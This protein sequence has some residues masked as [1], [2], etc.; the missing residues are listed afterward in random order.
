MKSLGAR[1]VV[2]LAVACVFLQPL[3]VVRAAESATAQ[4]EA[5]NRL[6]EQGRFAEAASAYE[7]ILAGGRA[8]PALY[9]NLGNARFKAGQ[10]G[11]A[12][13]AY[14]RAA[15]RAPRDPDVLANLRFARERVS[16]PTL[17]P[18]PLD[19]WL[20]RLSLNEWTGLATGALWTLLVLL[21][22][23]QV[24]PRLRPPLRWPVRLALVATLLLGLALAVVWTRASRALLAVVTVQE[25]IARNGPFEE[26]PEA[27]RL[28][29]GAEL[30]VLDRK[31]DWLQVSDGR[32][33]PAWVKR[34]AV[35]LLTPF[36][37]DA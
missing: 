11:R 35:F 16:G 17:R 2:V 20:S 34:D 4:F 6:Y 29:D 37:N 24:W 30:R 32:G 12:L 31:D 14:R 1:S 5:A 36:G 10:V 22:A 21:A 13:V 7:A 3:P 28:H 18:G 19:R 23:G 8:S 9:F 26:S 15:E 25:T 33:R 27:F